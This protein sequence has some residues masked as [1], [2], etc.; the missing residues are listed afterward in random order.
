MERDN[1]QLPSWWNDV[2]D[3]IPAQLAE[4]EQWQAEQI[5]AAAQRLDETRQQWG[6]PRPP[7][8]S[9][10]APPR[11]RRSSSREPDGSRQRLPRAAP[12]RPVTPPLQLYTG[13]D[14]WSIPVP[15]SSSQHNVPPHLD[16]PEPTPT[17][18]YNA[19]QDPY[20]QMAIEQ[21][22]S[23][24]N[25]WLTE[26]YINTHLVP[27][28]GIPLAVSAAAP[29][30]AGA[31]MP[32]HAQDMLPGL[33]DAGEQEQP[34]VVVGEFHKVEVKSPATNG[35]K[36][37]FVV[38]TPTAR[39]RNHYL[40]LP[41]HVF[42]A[43]VNV[44]QVAVAAWKRLP[45]RRFKDN[46]DVLDAPP[47]VLDPLE[48]DVPPPD[49]QLAGDETPCRF[50]NSGSDLCIDVWPT[51]P[52]NHIVLSRPKEPRAG[53][54]G[55]YPIVRY[56]PSTD[57]NLYLPITMTP[58][59]GVHWSPSQ[60]A[61]NISLT[62]RMRYGVTVRTVAIEIKVFHTHGN[63]RYKPGGRK[64]ATQQRASAM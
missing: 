39:A 32:P 21:I 44:T 36:G 53:S 64:M 42:G 47:G 28:D 22:Q 24:V 34:G 38:H 59:P 7:Q 9:P 11:R 33:D 35:R 52:E 2:V 58:R 51:P 1:T 17:A 63:K 18:P 40:R 62:M 41:P 13:D 3:D 54:A 10:V 49:Q 4:A 56:E 37:N 57:E 60:D 8:P 14:D 46:K 30:L 15:S 19:S 16:T 61:V 25:A 27:A 45:G 23:P 12:S 55:F 20:L 31:P 43:D 6:G 48:I 26:D 29:L 5:A 50:G